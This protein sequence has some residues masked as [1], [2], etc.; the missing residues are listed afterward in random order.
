[1]IKYSGGGDKS[2][3][4]LDSP[5]NIIHWSG[6]HSTLPNVDLMLDHRPRRWFNI[7][8][9]LG[10]RTVLVG[11]ILHVCETYWILSLCIVSDMHSL[12]DWQ[13]CSVYTL[14]Q[15]HK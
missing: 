6:D 4:P 15:S 2:D 5:T 10:Q 9:T 11:K 3:E 1:M 8:T 14:K 12:Y 7:K 13:A